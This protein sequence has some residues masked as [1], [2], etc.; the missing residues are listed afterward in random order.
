MFKFIL[1]TNTSVPLYRQLMDQVRRGIASGQLRPGETLPSVR[2]VARELAVNP[3]TVSK[4]YSL[5][6]HDGVLTRQR[7]QGML[8][9]GPQ[10]TPEALLAPALGRVIREAQQL[11]LS[12]TEV[13][14]LIQQHWEDPS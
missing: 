3:N 11:G 10:E 2:D 1:E 6:E 4:V 14:R 7:G 12:R 5:L 13:V 9:A 8:V